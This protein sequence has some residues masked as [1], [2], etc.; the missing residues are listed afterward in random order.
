MTT[1]LLT[2]H[3]LEFLSLK[4]G[5]TGS[6]EST[7]VKMP[8]CWKSH[9]MAQLCLNI[10][11]QPYM[12]HPSPKPFPEHT[13]QV[14]LHQMP[15]TAQPGKPFP[16]QNLHYPPP[17]HDQQPQTPPPPQSIFTSPVSPGTSNPYAWSTA[18]TPPSPGAY[19]TQNR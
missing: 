14:N 7:L 6:Y 19:F 12:G 2:E 8:H 17:L 18:V 10:T 11:G 5:C 15:P 3:H 4:G 1:K 9:I 13:P 16:E